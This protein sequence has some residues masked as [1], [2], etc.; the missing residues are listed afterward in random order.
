VVATSVL[1][2][3][4]VLLPV[5]AVANTLPLVLVSPPRRRRGAIVVGVLTILVPFALEQ[6]GVLPTRYV[7][8]DGAITILPFLASY[9]PLPTTAFLVFSNVALVVTACFFVAR[10]RDAQLAAEERV[11]LHAWQLR[12]MTPTAAHEA[13][14][15]V[16]PPSGPHCV[17]RT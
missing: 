11:I 3:S 15:S 8:A 12:Q 10:F 13:M 4:L 9:T 14:P 16:H 2:G 6:L 1:F 7:F 17:L 5:V